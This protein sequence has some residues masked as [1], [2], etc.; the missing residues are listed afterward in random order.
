M[1]EKQYPQ[2]PWKEVEVHMFEF[3]HKSLIRERGDPRLSCAVCVCVCVWVCV[4]VCVRCVRCV[5]VMCK[6]CI[7]TTAARPQLLLHQLQFDLAEVATSP[8][9][10]PRHASRPLS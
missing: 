1:F 2:Y 4:C 7:L 6:V 8:P 5:Y 3:S 9:L 10:P